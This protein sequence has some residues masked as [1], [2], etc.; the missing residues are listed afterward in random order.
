MEIT[1]RKLLQDPM[2]GLSVAAGQVGLDRPIM[3]AELNRPSLELTGYFAAFRS[4]RIQIF[5]NGEVSYIEANRRDSELQDNLARI[6]KDDVPCAIVTNGRK[7]PA[8]MSAR[9]D[10]AG[11]PVLTCPHSTTKLYKR[12]WENLE[13]EFAPETTIHGV[14]MDIH[15]MGV[16][17]LGESSVG[18]SE[19]GLELIRRGFHLVADDMVTVKCLSDS[20]LVGRGSDLLPYHME[21]RGLGIIDVSRLFGVTAIRQDKRISMAITLADWDD[22]EE[23]DR[24]GLTEEMMTILDVQLP[25]VTIPVKP[26]RS[27]GTLVEIAALNQKLKKMGIHTARL[28]EERLAERMAAGQSG[29]QNSR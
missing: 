23:Y 25:H 8:L 26:G 10:A 29:E 2:L 6:L 11:I 21:A 5:G 19:C 27:V 17:I 22:D 16:L 13:S 18:K 28:M 7:P 24:T 9:A 15:D 14:L 12:L 20:I 1:V 3:T 4:E